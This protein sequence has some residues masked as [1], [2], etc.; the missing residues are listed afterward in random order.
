MLFLQFNNFRVPFIFRD[1]VRDHDICNRTSK[2]PCRLHSPHSKHLEVRLSLQLDR[3]PEPRPWIEALLGNVDEYVMVLLQLMIGYLTVGQ[4]N[5]GDIP[6]NPLRRTGVRFRAARVLV[7]A[8]RGV[9]DV[10]VVH[11]TTASAIPPCSGERHVRETDVVSQNAHG[12]QLLQWRPHDVYLHTPSC[13]TAVARR[14]V[15]IIHRPAFD[16]HVVGVKQHL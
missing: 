7:G 13:G 11:R 5:R 14:I 4:R 8:E 6:P 9:K 2:R 15:N 1:S 12:R 16:R 10:N 3:N